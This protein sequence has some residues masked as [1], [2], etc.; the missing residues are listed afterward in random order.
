[1]NKA[2]PH[3]WSKTTQ[4]LSAFTNLPQSRSVSWRRCLLARSPACCPQQHRRRCFARVPILA[5][6]VCA[7]LV[8]REL[9]L[10]ACFMCFWE[11]ALALVLVRA[12]TVAEVTCL[13]SARGAVLLFPTPSLNRRGMYR[14]SVGSGTCTFMGTWGP[15]MD[16]PPCSVH[17]TVT[18]SIQPMQRACIHSRTCMS[19]VTVARATPP[20][21][22]SCMQR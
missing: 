16:S 2:Y 22:S 21:P 15:S 12:R 7:E 8:L 10:Y 13:L 5:G 11:L 18:A 20:R 3:T 6:S 1:M 19:M 9:V 4:Q 14:R 17:S